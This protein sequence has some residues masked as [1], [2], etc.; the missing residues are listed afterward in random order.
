[1]RANSAPW[2]RGLALVTLSMQ[3]ILLFYLPN[4][5]YA[6]LAWLLVFIVV[7]IEIRSLVTSKFVSD[8]RLFKRSK[9]VPLEAQ[10]VP[11]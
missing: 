2:L 6:L 4:G 1:L 10:T 9:D 8:N 7:L 3:A 5:R 11:P